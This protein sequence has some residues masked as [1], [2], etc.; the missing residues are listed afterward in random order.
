MTDIV[1]SAASPTS[2][3]LTSSLT[4]LHILF[5]PHL[6][7]LCFYNFYIHF[8]PL[9]PS[10]KA[11]LLP[12]LYALMHSPHSVLSY[13]FTRAMT[14]QLTTFYDYSCIHSTYTKQPFIFKYFNRVH[15]HLR[16]SSFI[17]EYCFILLL[18]VCSL[19]IFQLT[20]IHTQNYAVIHFLIIISIQKH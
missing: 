3:P 8:Y 6:T 19:Q 1:S 2:H 12:K 10:T 16:L 13:I 11:L 9:Y 15:F 20:P 14:N 17:Y 7:D 4:I 18:L 5:L